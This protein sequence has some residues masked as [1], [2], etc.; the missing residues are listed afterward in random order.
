MPFR[1]GGGG[2]FVGNLNTAEFIDQVFETFLT[3]AKAAGGL[4]WISQVPTRGKGTTPDF[5]FLFHRGSVGTPA[6]PYLFGQTAAK[7][8]Y[9]FTGNG[10][11]TAQESFDQP[12][13][14]MNYPGFRGQTPTDPAPG[15]PGL[16]HGSSSWACW[17]WNNCLGPYDD[18]WL[19]GGPTGEYCHMVLKVSA[20]EY[21]HFHVGLLTPLHPDFPADA[22]YV[23]AHRWA[24][25]DPDQPGTG[26]NTNQQQHQPYHRKHTYPFRNHALNSTIGEFGDI[27]SAPAI[28]H[29]PGGYGS[30][31]YEWWLPTGLEVTSTGGSGLPTSPSG[32]AKNGSGNTNGDAPIQKPIGDVNNVDDSVAI[33]CAQLSSSS[34]GLGEILKACRAT[35]TTD[36]VSLIPITLSLFSDFE[37]ANR[38][39]PVAQV[40]DVYRVSMETFAP[41]QEI[42][43]GGEPYVVF[44]AINKD[45]GNT[46]ANEGY[47]GYEGL[48]YRKIT[49]NAT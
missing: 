25:K 10:V 5:E 27:R 28:F 11:D 17:G 9:A 36:G 18:Y 38:W 8:W 14:P 45:S 12:G 43:I 20:R 33:G 29:V 26:T 3:D 15:D 13:N 31:A 42:L 30:D 24:Y 46:L 2:G 7:T 40:P 4:G 34:A 39:G 41:E 32:R 16:G 19:F 6:P 22:H 23:T 47:S 35:F 21:R 37:S 44:P 48:A 1:T 49:A